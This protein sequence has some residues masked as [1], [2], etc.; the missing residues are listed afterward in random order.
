[1]IHI[2]K[3][4]AHL[5]CRMNDDAQRMLCAPQTVVCTM[6]CCVHHRLLCAPCPAVC[7]TDCCVHHRLLCAPCPAVCTMS[8]CV[9][10][11]LL[12]APCPAVCNTAS[13]GT[14]TLYIQ[15]S[16]TDR[17]KYNNKTHSMTSIFVMIFTSVF[18]KQQQP[19]PKN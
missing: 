14:V 4:P 8:C 5:H 9:Q 18:G 17:Y 10:H 3:R 16:Y 11:R 13:E 1:V 19:I 15:L 12:F 6:S 7:T 2:L